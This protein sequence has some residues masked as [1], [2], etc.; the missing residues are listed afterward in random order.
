MQKIKEKMI[1][2]F[3]FNLQKFQCKLCDD[4]FFAAEKPCLAH[5]RE[6]HSGIS[7]KCKICKKIFRRNDNPHQC[8]ASKEQYYQF[9]QLNGKKGE[10]AE[11]DLEVFMKKAREELCVN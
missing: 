2:L 1:F 7:Y 11:K 8:R 6:Q 3:F 4:L 10:E 5:L 9:N